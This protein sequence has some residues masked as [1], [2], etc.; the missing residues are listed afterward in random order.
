MI[1]D[2]EAMALTKPRS[3]RKLVPTAASPKRGTLRLALVLAVLVGV[4]L[5][6]FLWRGNTSIPAVMEQAAMAGREGEL[7]AKPGLAPAKP[8]PAGEA[9]AAQAGS[10][11]G[12]G[13]GGAGATEGTT[14][15]TGEARLVEG[16]VQNGDSL[17]RILR[18]EGMTPPEADELIRTLQEHMDLR[19]IRPGQSYRLRFD[20]GG[21]MESFEFDVSR[22]VRVRAERDASGNLVG[23]SDKA[24][25]DVRTEEIG[26][27]IDSSLFAAM[28]Q[29]GEDA[30]LVSFFVDV[31]AYDID[32][33]SDTHSGDTFRMLVEK[34][35]LDNAFL[36]YR[37]VLA[38]EYQGKAGTFHAFW[39]KAP[40]SS[41]GRYFNAAGESVEKSLLKTPLKFARI[42][43]RFNLKRMHPV[44]HRQRAHLGVDYAAP[45]GTAVWAAA[46][47]R[48]VGRGNMGGAGNCVILQHDN[49][50]QTVYMHLSKFESG[51]RVGE[52]VKSK[53]VIGYVGAT[54][55]ATGPHLHF[56]VKQ[57]GQYVDP[58]T[59]KLARGPGVPRKQ[60]AQ[61][62]AETGALAERLLR[63]PIS[64]DEQMLVQSAN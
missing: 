11:E 3:K 32:F 62:K 24:S 19:S 7:G 14:Q 36:R 46:D 40:G 35:Y 42:S 17:G 20:A 5:Y 21:R 31:F 34:E 64:A 15:G 49:G 58:S 60:R 43:S 63:I 27:R 23:H 28:K 4:N 30:S 50:L 57:K 2:R 47:G 61:F 8:A 1:D 13:E 53:T 29:A 10:A 52:R 18:R 26:G 55:L 25:T 48:I 44:L 41:E 16:E 33:F 56:G 12:G 59:L 9:T 54:G 38:A 51:Q 45:T 6:V 22:T 37:R 39:W